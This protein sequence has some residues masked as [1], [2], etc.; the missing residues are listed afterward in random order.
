MS[1]D[2]FDGYVIEKEFPVCTG[3]ICVIV[4]INDDNILEKEELLYVSL[5]LEETGIVVNGTDLPVV[6]VDNDEG[7]N[8]S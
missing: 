7:A 1:P 2:D 4:T 3:R 5:S 8:Q 6:I